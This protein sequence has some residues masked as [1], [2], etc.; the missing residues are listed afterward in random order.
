MIKQLFDLYTKIRS[1]RRE[2]SR[3]VHILR[4]IVIRIVRVIFKCHAKYW[5]W[6]YSNYICPA[7][8]NRGHHLGVYKYAGIGGWLC[9]EPSKE[10]QKMLLESMLDDQLKG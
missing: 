10:E 3:L 6:K 1:F 9:A 4:V 7:C 2:D 8:K 5:D